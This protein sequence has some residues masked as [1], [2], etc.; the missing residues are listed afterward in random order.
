MT[1][2]NEDLKQLKDNWILD[3]C[4]DIEETEGFEKYYEELKK[5]RLKKEKEWEEQ[6]NAELQKIADKKGITDINVVRY[7]N[8]L[9]KYYNLRIME[10]EEKLN[11]IS[12]TIRSQR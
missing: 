8:N 4:W 12:E 9:E 7:I 6:R 2:G 10:L 11:K 1:I 3:P 5:F